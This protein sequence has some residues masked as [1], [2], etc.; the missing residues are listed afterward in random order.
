MTPVAKTAHRIMPALL[1]ATLALG[2][3]PALAQAVKTPSSSAK[4]PAARPATGTEDLD[5]QLEDA[6]KRLEQAAREVAEL[7]A[8]RTGDAGVQVIRMRAGEPQ[9]AMLGVNVGSA[10]EGSGGV[11]VVSV[12]PGG[13]AAEAG[14]AIGDVI[15]GVN[16]RPVRGGQE[17]V[18]AMQ[19]VEPGERVGLDVRRGGRDERLWVVARPFGYPGQLDATLLPPMPGGPFP[20]GMHDWLLGGFGDAEFATITPDLGRYFGTDRGVLV[21]RAPTGGDVRLKDG[22]VIL[23]IDGRR[24]D[25]A[26]H[27]MRILRSYQPGEKLVLE[28]MRDRK[29]L[30]LQ[31]TAPAIE[32]R[33]RVKRVMIAPPAPPAPT[34]PPAPPAPP[35]R[36]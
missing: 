33:V 17:L 20:E 28:V 7:S 31:V 1:A 8:Q 36:P 34:A 30:K 22:D 18:R 21:V 23:S 14:V 11:R 32:S 15:V 10:D 35:A 3:G 16:D 29:P 19:D 24:P 2:A 26:P 5:R 13:P 27:A 25:D 6:R 12:S 4:P 9:R